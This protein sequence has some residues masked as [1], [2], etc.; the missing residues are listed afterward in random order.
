MGTESIRS[1]WC[2]RSL[3][4]DPGRG[5]STR[6]P[7]AQDVALGSDPGRVRVK[8]GNERLEPLRRIGRLELAEL[9]QE[10]LRAT[11]LVDDAQL[12]HPPV[13]LFDRDVTEQSEHVA[14]DAVLH[15]QPVDGDRF[16]LG[17][18]LL[19]EAS[20]PRASIGS[21]IVEAV[22]VTVV[23]IHG[24]RDRT[25]LQKRFPEPIGEGID[26]FNGSGHGFLLGRDFFLLTARLRERWAGARRK[27]RGTRR[28][29][30]V[31]EGG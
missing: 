6:H 11:D 22:V 21:R 28:P 12:V 7:F 20:K 29:A 3:G 8:P 13:V 17:P 30:R 19:R 24:R 15:G 18:S 10:R 4:D 2:D 23:A 9:G 5:Q 31:S 27:S 25:E 16:G 26:G 14:G 1:S